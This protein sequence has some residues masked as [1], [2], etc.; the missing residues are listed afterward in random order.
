MKRFINK[1]IFGMTSIKYFFTRKT[2]KIRDFGT[3]YFRNAGVI[4][5]KGTLI[6]NANS[7]SKKEYSKIRIDQNGVLR[8][9][10]VVQLFVK[11]NIHVCAQAVLSIGDGTYINEGAKISCKHK[12]EIGENCAIS[13]DVSIMDS[14]FHFISGSE[15]NEIGVIIGNHCWIGV[16]VIVLK[17]VRIGGNCIIGAGTLVTKNIPDNC[18]V[19]GNPMRIIKTRVNWK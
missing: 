8:V 17:N 3:T 4:D 9:N 12:I 5:G 1:I 6:I 11:A 7:I 10:G 18:M 19:V 13:N 2:I 16:N 14:D 15:K